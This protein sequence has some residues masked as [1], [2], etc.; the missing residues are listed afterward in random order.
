MKPLPLMKKIKVLHISPDSVIHGTERH[1]LALVEYSNRDIVENTV[2]TPRKGVMNDELDRLNVKNFIAGRKHGYKGKFR[3]V[4]SN[5]SR[6]LFR[7]I[8]EG[9]YDIVHTHLN[10]FGG[11]IGKLAGT[12]YAVH[13]RHGVFWSEEELEHISAPDKFFQLFKSKVFDRTVAIG[14]YEK[15]TLIEK[16]K[17]PESKII[18]TING[19][20][21]DKILSGTNSAKSKLDIFGT[22]DIIAGSTGRLERQ[23]GFHFII[24]AA[25]ILKNKTPRLKFF[26][27]GSGKEKE[28]LEKLIDEYGLRDKVFLYDYKQ[29]ILDYVK[30]F[31]MMLSTSLWEGLSYSVQEAMALGKPV[32]SFTA[33]HVSGVKEIIEDG[34]SGFL[35][36]YKDSN[37]LAGKIYEL[38]SNDELRIN[39]GKAAQE[40]IRNCFP[41]WQTAKDMDKL[42]IELMISN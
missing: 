5:D 12:K 10:S 1:I 26:I 19:V 20:N 18:R 23:K 31:D 39:F 34:V 13:T 14:N 42:Y 37:A 8:K 15:Q 41:E 9:G 16:F 40:K 22:N 38:F 11:F 24:E 21:I 29:N 33:P 27:I 30:C 4:L 17:Y 28:N 3:G 36:D 2:V 32:I 6:S 7:L 35:V 25:N